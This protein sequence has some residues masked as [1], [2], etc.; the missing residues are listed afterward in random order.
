LTEECEEIMKKEGLGWRVSL[1]IIVGVSW[2][3]FVI[4]WLFFY[5]GEYSWEKNFA[6]VL[7]SILVIIGILGI[8]WTIWGMKHR[9][10]HEIEMCQTKGFKWRIIL[11]CTLAFILIIFL[12][13]WFWF[14]AEPYS[15]YQ[16]IAIFIVAILII[17]GV[18]GASW[19]PWGIKHGH[20]FEEEK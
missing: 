17:G 4:L 6:I 18:V 12:I 16:N 7:L 3:V 15:V 20:K 13:Y 8:P 2:L 10:K 14:L 11:S 19:A 9:K 5:A 1:S